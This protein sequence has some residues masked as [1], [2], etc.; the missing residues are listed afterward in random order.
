MTTSASTDF[1]AS[2]GRSTCSASMTMGTSGLTSLITDATDPA[3]QETQLVVEDNRI[4]RLRHEEPQTLGT[5]SRGY[6]LVSVL[7]QQTQLS[8]IPVN[9]QQRAV[10]SHRLMYTGRLSPTSDQNCS[11]GIGAS[12]R[13]R[14]EASNGPGCGGAESCRTTRAESSRKSA[15][16]LDDRAP[17]TVS[18]IPP[19]IR[20]ALMIGDTRSL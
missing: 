9:A 4:H 18:A 7:L 20:T 11:T 14:G 6:Q 19:A 1:N 12:E 8:R 10:R 15:Q 13:D 16:F 3:I 17:A 2:S 5:A